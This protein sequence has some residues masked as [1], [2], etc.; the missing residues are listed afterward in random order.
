MAIDLILRRLYCKTEYPKWVSSFKGQA[1]R[2]FIFSPAG[3]NPGGF[4]QL[5][6][7]VV[8]HPLV[9]NPEINEGRWEF[10]RGRLPKE[11]ASARPRRL[12]TDS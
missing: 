3:R 12:K 11:S 6:D 9:I 5:Y 1:F 8:P 2:R 10:L 7:I 4:R